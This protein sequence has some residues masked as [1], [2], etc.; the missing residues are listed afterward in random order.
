ML[1]LGF[2]K[3][4]WQPEKLLESLIL[5]AQAEPGGN[6]LLL[7]FLTAGCLLGEAKLMTVTPAL[8][9]RRSSARSGMVVVQEHPSQTHA[10]RAC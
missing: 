7:G 10:Y 3:L 8:Q 9:C 6:L 5:Q 4:V 2:V 1:D